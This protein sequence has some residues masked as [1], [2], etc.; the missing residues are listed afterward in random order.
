[1]GRAA[2][3]IEDRG[4]VEGRITPAHL[5]L[6]IRMTAPT[7]YARFEGRI[8][9]EMYN[10]GPYPLRLRLREFAVGQLIF[11]CWGRAPSGQFN[12]SVL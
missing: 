9:L 11:E 6:A 8:V 2:A 3:Q 4:A 1:V 5:G 12:T 7:I 10:L